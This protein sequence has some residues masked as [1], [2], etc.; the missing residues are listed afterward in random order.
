MERRATVRLLCY[1]TDRDP[2]RQ[3]ES[4]T[5][6]AEALS[7]ASKLLNGEVTA[8]KIKWRTTKQVKLDL[9]VYVGDVAVVGGWLLLVDGA[10]RLVMP[11]CTV[12]LCSVLTQAEEADGKMPTCE[13]PIVVVAIRY[14]ASH[15]H[16][17][18]AVPLGALANAKKQ[19]DS[20]T[21]NAS[22]IVAALLRAKVDRFIG[23]GAQKAD[24]RTPCTRPR[25]PHFKLHPTHAML[26]HAR[27]PQSSG[28]CSRS[29]RLAAPTRSWM[30]R[31]G[32]STTLCARCCSPSWR[33]S[34]TVMMLAPR[35]RLRRR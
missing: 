9:N 4:E 34:P 33:R 25:S 7:R 18:T 22:A 13:P 24:R 6:V 28:P 12:T 2:G 20:S 32:S 23:A 26:T 19:Y 15:R 5:A 17:L 8:E 27:L 11:G 16:T 3:W 21:G 30:T 29:P 35:R 14:G 10:L 31:R 1:A